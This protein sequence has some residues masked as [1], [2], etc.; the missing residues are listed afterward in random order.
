[1]NPTPIEIARDRWFGLT[2]F[3]DIDV[4]TWTFKA[5]VR[6]TRARTSNLL[7][8]FSVSKA[9]YGPQPDPESDGTYMGTPVTLELQEN[10]TRAIVPNFG[11]WDLVGTPPGGEPMT[12]VFGPALIVNYP[13]EM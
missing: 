13:T 6:A 3:F 1:M 11:Y 10:I 7:A 12:W 5:Q 9:A 4:T 8:E 2:C